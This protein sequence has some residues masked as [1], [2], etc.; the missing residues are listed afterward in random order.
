MRHTDSH[1]LS[2]T[3]ALYS[4]TPISSP[5]KSDPYLANNPSGTSATR[6]G[7]R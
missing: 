1:S 4:Y 3:Q 5:S 6:V 7:G 2:Y